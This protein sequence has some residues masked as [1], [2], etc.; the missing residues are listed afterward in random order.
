ML[1]HLITV[2]L[3]GLGNRMR[4]IA[5]ARR[6]CALHGARCTVMWNW[7]RPGLFF[8]AAPDVE[9]SES[10]DGTEGY[11]VVRHVGEGK[12][13]RPEDRLVPTR[14][15]RRLIVHS[16][17]VFSARE[18]GELSSESALKP[19]L[20]RPSEGV[21]RA[22]AEFKAQRLGGR[23]AGMHLRQTDNKK[24]SACAP[25]ATYL[26]EGRRLVG[27][28]YR[29]FVAADNAAAKR[30]LASAFGDRVVTYPGTEREADRWPRESVSLFDLVQDLVEFHLLAS[31]DLVVG[32]AGSSYSRL[33]AI[34]NGSPEC[35]LLGWDLFRAWPLPPAGAAKEA[36]A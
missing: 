18:E 30:A 26:E 28:G 27:E 20:P 32:S 33:A 17:Y 21:R 31:C 11:T 29:L 12:G 23:V 36:R 16:C 35:R 5:S 7:G 24:A 3:A 19:W 9:W 8:A 10:L 22:A 14:E 25:L 13:G 2:P 4:V 15:H 6:L 34:Y 1:E